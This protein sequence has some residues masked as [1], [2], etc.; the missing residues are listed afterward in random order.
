[1]RR[2]PFQRDW[3]L[4]LSRE[5]QPPHI[6]VSALLFDQSGLSVAT[7]GPGEKVILKKITI[8]RDLGREIE[9]ATGIEAGDRIILSP[10]DGLVEGSQVRIAKGTAGGS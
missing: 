5:V 10:P 2:E 9:I 7:V 8:A 4:D 1:M 6:P 3:G